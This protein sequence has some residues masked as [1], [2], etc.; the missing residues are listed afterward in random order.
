MNTKQKK[1]Q[2][3]KSLIRGLHALREYGNYETNHEITDRVLRDYPTLDEQNILESLEDAHEF[4]R[5]LVVQNS[6]GKNPLL[7]F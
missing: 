3:T 1:I 7:H 4:I 6:K 2:I 5:Q